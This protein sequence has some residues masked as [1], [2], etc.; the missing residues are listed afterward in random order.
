MTGSELDVVLR[1]ADGH[2]EEEGDGRDHRQDG[3]EGSSRTVLTTADVDIGLHGQGSGLVAVEDD[4]AGE[5]GDYGDPAQDGTGNDAVGHHG[6]GD[7]DKGLQ[8]GGTETDGSLLNA[9]GDLHQGRRGR[10]DRVRHPSYG[11]RHDHDGSGAGQGEGLRAIG[12]QQG[13]TDDRAGHNIGQ[14]G[15]GVQ[16]VVQSTAAAYHQV[17]EDDGD[18]YDDDQSHDSHEDGILRSHPEL[19]LDRLLIVAE[20]EAGAEHRAPALAE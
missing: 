6:D 9:D 19:F 16:S 2:V 3:G 11:K 15:D 13:D 5:L 20:G 18:H 8:L 4:G 12:N 1:L 17:G 14:H 10:A 7:L